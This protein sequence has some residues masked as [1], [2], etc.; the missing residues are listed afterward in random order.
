MDEKVRIL[1]GH[2]DLPPG[3]PNPYHFNTNTSTR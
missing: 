2:T 3:M 1:A